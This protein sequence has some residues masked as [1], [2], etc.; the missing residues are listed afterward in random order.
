MAVRV[1]TT[2]LTV[3]RSPAI[4][5]SPVPGLHATVVL[6]VHADVL[7]SSSMIACAVGVLAT[8]P[9][10]SPEIVTD[11]RADDGEFVLESKLVTGAASIAQVLLPIRSFMALSQKPVCR[12]QPL[13]GVVD[14]MLG[15]IPSKV[16]GATACV[17]KTPPTVMHGTALT[18]A[19][20]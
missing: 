16:K 15:C 3:I 8:A 5:L 9:K 18:K 11:M 4:T 1:P 17:P 2:A 12:S 14:P 10:L 19:S 7:H 6:D 20:P 13:A